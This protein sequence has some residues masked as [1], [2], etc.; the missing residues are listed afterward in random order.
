MKRIY[1]LLVLLIATS[2]LTGCGGL[3]SASDIRQSGKVDD[4][5]DPAVDQ[6]LA[7]VETLRVRAAGSAQAGDYLAQQRSLEQALTL[8]G[9]LDPEDSTSER[10]DPRTQQILQDLSR[11][12][13][14]ATANC[15]ELDSSSTASLVVA[16]EDTFCQPDSMT[17][18]AMVPESLGFSPGEFDFPIEFNHRVKEKIVFW[19]TRGRKPFSR[20]LRNYCHYGPAIRDQLAELGLPRDLVYLAMIE[21]G[22]NPRAYSYAR[23]AGIWQF[24]PG[25]AKNY[26]LKVDWW[27]DERR[28]PEKSTAAAVHYLKD[29]YA[30]FNDWNLALAGYNCGEGGVGRRMSRQ[31]KDTYWKLNLPRQTMDY[32]PL[33]MAAAII[34]KHPERFGFSMPECSSWPTEKVKIPGGVDLQVLA[35]CLEMDVDAVRDMNPELTRFIVPEEVGTYDLRVPEGCGE[36]VVAK[37]DQIPKDQRIVRVE[38]RVTSGE[39]LGHIARRYGVSLDAL[40]AVN[41]ITTGTRLSVGRI[42]TIPL[43]ASSN[44]ARRDAEPA[45]EERAVEAPVVVK[46]TKSTDRPGAYRVR[47]GDTLSRLALNFGISV[48][49]LYRWNDLDENSVIAIGS[50]LIVSSAGSGK[51]IRYR[52]RAGETTERVAARFGLAAADVRRWNDLDDHAVLTAGQELELYSGDMPKPKPMTITPPPVPK[53]LPTTASA[54]DTMRIH[55]VQKGDTLNNIAARYAVTTDSI[56]TTNALVDLSH[57]R[58]GQRLAIP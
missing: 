13:T 12:L 22:L 46:K 29:L 19:Q 6:T 47:P 3:F 28:D 56:R 21:S 27:H 39:T 23:A 49:D 32:V 51:Q 52:T 42:L 48:S 57:L 8:L 36:F 38:H 15:R 43:E 1:L 30:M 25:T 24:I 20:F 54:D 9:E 33:F 44:L 50:T 18:E 7:Q 37:L 34:S 17:V 53:I 31:K 55:V 35:D 5:A 11:E 4:L 16:M 58:V 10:M 45:P 2:A 41:K 26:K 40:C 14:T